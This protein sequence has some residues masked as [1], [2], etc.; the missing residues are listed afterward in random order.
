MF[1]TNDIIKQLDFFRHSNKLTI[2]EICRGIMS[3]K[4]FTRLLNGETDISFDEIMAFLSRMNIQFQE[5]ILY[6]GNI[7]ESHY[8]DESSF[9]QAVIDGDYVRAYEIYYPKLGDA[10]YKTVLGR[11]AVSSFIQLMLFKLEKQER[12]RTLSNIQKDFPLDDFINNYVVDDNQI[13]ILYTYVNICNEKDKL[14]IGSYI[15]NIIFSD[16]TK[17]LLTFS[18]T[19]LNLLY[20]TAI[21]AFITQK[22][23]EEEEIKKLNLIVKAALEY[24]TKAR[25]P[26]SDFLL[27]QLLHD[28]YSRINKKNKYITF[29]YIATYISAFDSKNLSKLNLNE[30]DIKQFSELV[31][32]KEF[33]YSSMFERLLK[34]EI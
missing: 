15:S 31:Q 10:P 34:D 1:T 22:Q 23:L 32:D 7:V 21:L 3:R 17:L 28:Y 2:Q 12:L 13:C 27:F 5:F 4:K 20:K 14:K 8:P 24:Q 6:L 11:Q 19:S 18:S 9:C 26:M 30:D 29:Y 25:Q 33:R 16:R